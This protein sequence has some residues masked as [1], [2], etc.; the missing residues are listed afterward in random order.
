MSNKAYFR[1]MFLSQRATHLVELMDDPNANPNMLTNTYQSF[2]VINSLLAFWR[3]I[4]VNEINPL[5]KVDS[6]NTIA[7]IGCG[8]GYILH[9]IG[10][11][12]SNDGF[13]CELT[14]FE[15][16]YRAQ[17][18]VNFTHSIRFLNNHIQDSD[19][20]FDFII[21]NHVLHHLDESL[22]MPF[23]QETSKK[24]NIKVIHNDI[25]RSFLAYLLYPIIGLWLAKNTF[26][27]TDGLRSIRRSFSRRE[28]KEKVSSSWS[29]RKAYP[30]RVVLIHE[31]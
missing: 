24:A 28:L 11:W 20:T 1:R 6:I 23:L 2:R 19:E 12:A 27:L 26:I 8:D 13:K 25:S 10:I 9:K 4:Y 30:F 5:L 22:L 29:V 17:D 21:S 14:G 7:D 16:D 18:A 3:T 15:P 31:N